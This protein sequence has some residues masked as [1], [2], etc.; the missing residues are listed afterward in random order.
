MA[1][2]NEVN[3]LLGTLS[4]FSFLAPVAGLLAVGLL[5]IYIWNR[6]R[7]THSLMSRLWQIFHGKR[8]CKDAATAAFL[9]SQAALMQFRFMT[10]VHARTTSQSHALIEWAKRNNEDMGDI[11]ACGR[12]FDLEKISLKD[13]LPGARDHVAKLVIIIL[14]CAS[15]TALCVGILMPK[16]LIVFKESRQHF[17]LTADHA[18]PLWRGEGISKGQCDDAKRIAV[19]GFTSHD[20]PLI[21]KILNE[22]GIAKYV[23]QTVFE[24]RLLL[25]FV[26]FNVLGYLLGC[27]KWFMQGVHAGQM[28]N[29]IRLRSASTPPLEVMSG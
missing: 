19:S 8:D 6:T 3:G 2:T 12:Y 14:C 15:L 18:E 26:A 7:S 24:Q 1:P 5:S 25:G 4:S 11:A 21:C 10:G 23:S 13:E 17:T 28:R 22:E 29:R 16:A 9:D 27:W 20:A